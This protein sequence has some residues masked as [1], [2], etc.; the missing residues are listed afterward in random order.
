M[1]HPL[2]TARQRLKGAEQDIG[3]LNKAIRDFFA[4]KP[5]R[6]YID[7]KTKPGRHLYKVEFFAKVPPDWSRKVAHIAGDL[8]SPLDYAVVRVMEKNP[9]AMKE[10]RER[11][12]SLPVCRDVDTLKGQLKDRKILTVYP[13]L[14][15]FILNVVKPYRRGNNLVC[16]LEDINNPKKHRDLY[17]IGMAAPGLTL[18]NVRGGP[19]IIPGG[20]QRGLSKDCVVLLDADPKLKFD[21]DLQF[22]LDVALSEINAFE[23]QP[24]TRSLSEIAK[25]VR[26]LLGEFDRT[27]FAQ[28]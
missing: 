24:L 21:G 12:Q 19:F 5:Y 10:I 1:S 14:S 20:Y 26:R 25:E 6:T 7:K 23:R 16:S 8:R 11:N 22:S 13:E 9:I 2:D 17:P 18:R 3:D 27:F 28:P 4:L 15:D